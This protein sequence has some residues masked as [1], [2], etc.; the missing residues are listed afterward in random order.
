M[1]AQRNLVM[2]VDDNP[3]FVHHVFRFLTQAFEFGFAVEA[4]DPR[5]IAFHKRR[6]ADESLTVE[7]HD[8]RGD[9]PAALAA[10][11]AE[12]ERRLKELKH[13]A[14]LQV[15]A[16]IDVYGVGGPG[17]HDWLEYVR[18]WARVISRAHLRVVSSYS[19]H[20]DAITL[21]DGD[22]LPIL[23]HPKSPETLID[24]R[25]TLQS[26]PVRPR[27]ASRTAHVLLTG[28]GFELADEAECGEAVGMPWTHQL[29]FESGAH[30]R[31][32]ECPIDVAYPIPEQ[33]AGLGR[34]RLAP[35][36]AAARLRDLDAYWDQRLRLVR[37]LRSGPAAHHSSAQRELED[38]D[39]FRVAL[40]RYDF[41]HLAQALWAAQLDWSFWISTNYTRF[42]DRAVE[43]LRDF[44]QAEP[45]R[46]WHCI[47]TPI[48]SELVHRE[49][50]LGTVAPTAPRWLIKLHGDIGQTQSMALAAADKTD[51]VKFD[52]RPKLATMYTL[53]S[54]LILQRLER[55][56]PRLHT[57]Q[58]HVVG[59]GLRDRPL[60]ELLYKVQNRSASNESTKHIVTLVSPDADET[61][62]RLRSNRK[63]ALDKR[64]VNM[65]FETVG[66]TARHYMACLRAIGL[67][68][69][70][71]AR[72][73]LLEHV[74]Q[75][76][77][78]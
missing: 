55:S 20:L 24:L 4:G 37:S 70:D 52:V 31:V 59:H 51:K 49:L 26:A 56:S 8:P 36:L 66:T 69:D 1:S 6:S 71:Q 64:F 28:A 46:P 22:E 58:W 7:W 25:Q 50:V 14:S 57:C 3:K 17:P 41:G 33:L 2:V 65:R 19:R 12:F 23:I 34:R 75:P 29:L 11:L 45:F 18:T 62:D 27:A 13:H 38:R 67:P 63:L 5:S 61:L 60:L 42:S 78:P 44:A 40:L 21:D 9:G 32:D 16:L 74:R 77:L 39:T 73:N 54:E 76:A 35:L 15:W 43:F 48:E 10:R 72:A 53:A 68:D 47:T 30:H